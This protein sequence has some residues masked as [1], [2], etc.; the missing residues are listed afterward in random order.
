M[1]HKRG[2]LTVDQIKPFRRFGPRRCIKQ[3]LR[4]VKIPEMSFSRDLLSR[5]IPEGIFK[6]VPNQRISISTGKLLSFRHTDAWRENQRRKRIGRVHL[7]HKRPI[8]TRRIH[9]DCIEIYVRP[10]YNRRDH[11]LEIVKQ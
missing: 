11:R 9:A 3:G 7:L 2:R 6:A 4:L 5:P 10:N 8:L 1:A